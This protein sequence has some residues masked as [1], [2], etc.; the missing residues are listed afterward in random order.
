MAPE[1][2]R[3]RWDPDRWARVLEGQRLRVITS[4]RRK[5]IA[6]MNAVHCANCS[7]VTTWHGDPRR[8]WCVRQRCMVSNTFPKL[9]PEYRHA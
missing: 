1:A 3:E 6:G 5:S 9:C 7:G 4:E 8:G 2:N